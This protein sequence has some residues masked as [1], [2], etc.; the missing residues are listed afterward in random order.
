MPPLP[1]IHLTA[2]REATRLAAREPANARATLATAFDVAQDLDSKERYPAAWFIF[3]LNMPSDKETS[4]TASGAELLADL[5]AVVEHL[6]DAARLAVANLPPG[7]HTLDDLAAKWKVSRKT[8]DRYRK[9][10]LLAWR[11]RD[12]SGKPVLM[13]QPE[14]AERF[15]AR[16]EATIT[17]AAGFDRIDAA[18]EARMLRRARVY[19]VRFG[20][21][22]NQTAERLAERYGRSREAVRALL[23]RS[24]AAAETRTFTEPDALSARDGRVCLRAVQRGIEPALLARRFRKPMGSIRRGIGLAQMQQ[25]EP[26]MPA[27]RGLDDGSL[28]D[29]QIAA[30]LASPPALT[31]LDVRGVTELGAFL[32]DAAGPHATLAIEESTRAAAYRACRVRAAR[33][34][35]GLNH[36]FPGSSELDEI[37]T[38]LRWA[39]RLKAALVR[40][41]FRLCTQT[42]EAA[43]QTPLTGLKSAD[44]L[45]MSTELLAMLSD[46]VD[47][48]TRSEPRGRLASPVGLAVNK[49][50]GKWQKERLSAGPGKA[51]PRA[52]ARPS[53]ALPDWTARLNPWQRD[54]DPPE[55]LRSVLPRLSPASRELLT[56]RF[57]WDQAGSAPRTLDA[58]MAAL[59]WSR[60]K[61]VRAE[62]SAMHEALVL[63]RDRGGRA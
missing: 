39:S 33:V 37:I 60:I 55:W 59:G 63:V 20:C 62:R 19:R 52:T 11:V 14:H 57:G 38:L 16:H 21:T 43:F 15:A 41:Q 40:A 47:Q 23:K 4:A 1:H 26:H 22:L 27:L 56:L 30:A 53:G 25:I 7:W 50:A 17:R 9:K 46:M 34:H 2:L 49:L 48:H 42:M 10:G 31:G 44:A 58:C 35:A 61:A 8:V 45:A 28:S 12:E 36:N 13:V 3:R 51:A 5:A 54:L 24:H 18:T 6:T 29:A 32:D